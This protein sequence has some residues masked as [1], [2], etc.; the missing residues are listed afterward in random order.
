MTQIQQA[1]LLAAAM[2]GI[3]LL[4]S[5]GIVPKGFAEWAPFGLLALFP[6]AW[7]GAPKKC[8]EAQ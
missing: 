1:L 8:G 4:A 3:G 5:F 2:I 6:A 7:L